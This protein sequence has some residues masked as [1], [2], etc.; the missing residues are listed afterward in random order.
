MVR[1]SGNPKLAMGLTLFTVISNAILDPVF[2]FVLGMGVKGAA[3]ATVLCQLMSLA[4]TLRYF[5]N[6]ERF[7]HLPRE[8]SAYKVDWKIAKDSLAI[9][10]RMK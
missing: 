6:Q 7:L 2:I 3:I 5:L 1:A 9:G 8:L 4:Y 10:S